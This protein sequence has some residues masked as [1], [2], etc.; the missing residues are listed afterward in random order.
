M[1]Q[2]TDTSASLSMSAIDVDPCT[3][4]TTNR[5]LLNVQVLTTDPAGKATFRGAKTDFSPATRSVVFTITSGTSPGPEGIVAG[6][7]VQPIFDYTF[8]EIIQFGSPQIPLGFSLMPYLA[9]GSGPYVPGNLLT[10]PPA[11]QS[12]VG[13]LSPWPGAV[14]PAQTSCPANPPATTLIT[15]TLPTST[16]SPGGPSPDTITIVSATASKG[17]GQTTLAVVATTN[18]PNAKLSCAASGVNSIPP[19]P[20]IKAVDGTWSFS[21]STKGN[22]NSVTVTSDE[23]GSATRAV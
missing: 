9:K 19:T 8:P 2:S 5:P 6:S 3:G 16:P 10:P 17:Q 15:S 23:G 1:A 20:M 22:V 4:A 14:A 18:N 11:T 12:I 21:I 7:F 13:Q